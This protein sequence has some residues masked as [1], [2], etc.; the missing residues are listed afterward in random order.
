MNNEKQLAEEKELIRLRDEQALL[1]RKEEQA[2]L[3][4]IRKKQRSHIEE[5]RKKRAQKSFWKRYEDYIGYGLIGAVVLFIIYA[6]F[7]GD[8][9][10]P[11]KIQVNEDVYI[12]AQNE[13][14]LP[15][16]LK[17]NEFFEGTNMKSAQNI[18]NNLLTTENTQPICDTKPLGDVKVPATYNFY[19][20]HPSC[21]FVHTQ[22]HCS[23]S[24][25]EGPLSLI[26]N[27]LCL[28]K[29]DDVVLSLDYLLNCDTQ[30]NKGCKSGFLL[31][32]L[33]FGK[34]NGYVDQKCWDNLNLKEGQCPTKEQLE[35]CQRLN[36]SSYCVLKGETDI[37]K[38]I[39][40]NGPVL[41]LIQPYRD[42]LVL[43]S[44]VF[45]FGGDKTSLK[46]FQVVKIVGWG[47]ENNDQKTPYWLVENLWGESWG[48]NGLAKVE[49]KHEDSYLSKFAV[50]LY[51]K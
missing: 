28:S 16:N 47:T 51:V 42:F 35:G 15:Y 4:E 49:M 21:R 46:G 36:L 6:N 2:R 45:T 12:Q 27:R 26:R 18:F 40:K 7:S 9:R 3:E 34:D 44:G 1:K 8:R 39:F 13:E 48:Q 5:K 41:A 24:Y 32:S 43:D 25:A 10:S 33:Q 17:K 38:E 50:T 30:H 23:S 31:N 19:E 29:K 14:N 37:K 11:S 22:R 20:T